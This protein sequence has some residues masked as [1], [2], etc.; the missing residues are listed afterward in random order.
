MAGCRQPSPGRDH[1]RTTHRSDAGCAEGPGRATRTACRSMSCRSPSGGR[2]RGHGLRD[3]KLQPRLHGIRS[4]APGGRGDG[5][6][7][8]AGDVARR[9]GGEPGGGGPPARAP[10]W[11]SSPCSGPIR[12]ETG[13]RRR[14]PRPACR[15]EPIGRTTEAPTGVALI[16][17]DPEGRNQIAV[18]PG[19]NHRLTPERVRSHAAS[20]GARGRRAPP[21]RDADRHGALG[22]RGGAPSREANRAQPRAGAGAAASGRS[23]G[24]GRLP[25]A[26]RDRGGAAHGSRGPERDGR[27][28]R[29]PGARRPRECRPW[30]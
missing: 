17:V 15:P 4:A 16:S 27:G 14:W 7:R 29:G 8:H 30:W 12:W 28:G 13:S 24:A 26:Q 5:V 23:A 1:G 25:D 11:R 18:A 6:G 20:P 10:T 21:A 19:A 2:C 9:E 3:R 22:A